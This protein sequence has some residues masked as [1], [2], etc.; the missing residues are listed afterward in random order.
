MKFKVYNQ[1]GKVKITKTCADGMERPMFSDVAEGEMVEITVDATLTSK[2]HKY[3]T[4]MTE[5]EE[6]KISV[7]S[8]SR[9]LAMTVL[10]GCKPSYEMI[11]A[12]SVLEE[13]Q[14]GNIPEDYE[15]KVRDL[16]DRKHGNDA[17]FDKACD[18]LR[19]MMENGILDKEEASAA[20]DILNRESAKFAKVHPFDPI[21]NELASIRNMEAAKA[22]MM[23]LKDE[24]KGM[25]NADT[26][27]LHQ[28]MIKYA[29]AAAGCVPADVFGNIKARIRQ[30]CEEN[31]ITCDTAKYAIE[32]L[33]RELETL[34]EA[35]LM[36][37]T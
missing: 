31:N 26:V 27:M 1:N 29:A 2:S 25:D 37:M 5:E 28:Y 22:A 21:L 8:A 10:I 36:S 15:K 7:M 30:M 4:G 19:Q 18:F 20:I 32:V 11:L 3:V 35:E 17:L 13:A 12:S 14:K 23:I 24:M 34:S 16:V 6:P 33:D 9:A